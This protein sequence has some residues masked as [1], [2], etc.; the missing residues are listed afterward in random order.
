MIER[1]AAPEDVY[2]VLTRAAACRRTDSGRWR[3]DGV[4]RIGEQLS[5]VVELRAD[6]IVVTLFRGDE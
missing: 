2:E 5:L 4:D 6:V 1:D 3:L